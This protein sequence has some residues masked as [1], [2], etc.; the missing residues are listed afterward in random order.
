MQK[1]RI[2]KSVAKDEDHPY[3]V[4]IWDP[5]MASWTLLNCMS[6]L[7]TLKAAKKYLEEERKYDDRRKVPAEVVLEEEE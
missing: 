7:K 1:Y 6:G 2:I 4:Q 5:A 3:F